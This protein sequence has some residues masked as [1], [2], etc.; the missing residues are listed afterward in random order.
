MRRYSIP[1]KIVF[2]GKVYVNADDK[3][4]A[5]MIAETLGATIGDIFADDEQIK[6]WDI[7]M[8]SSKTYSVVKD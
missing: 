2:E 7:D 3:E 5:S 4:E 6:D 1:V 8:H